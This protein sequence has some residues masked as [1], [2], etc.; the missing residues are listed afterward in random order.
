V[1]N[2][3]V[4]REQVRQFCRTRLS[5]HKVPRIVKLIDAIPVDERGKVK[6]EALAQL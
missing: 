2:P 4:T 5:T 1:A 6:R 3:D